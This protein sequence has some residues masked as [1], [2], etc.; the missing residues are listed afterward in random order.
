MFA[1]KPRVESLPLGYQ[2]IQEE[3]T[4]RNRQVEARWI[5]FTTPL[6]AYDTCTYLECSLSLPEL[7]MHL[8]FRCTLVTLVRLRTALYPSV[9]LK[10]LTMSKVIPC[11]VE[12]ILLG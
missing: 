12:R 3:L 10:E 8:R 5:A 9:H 11:Y 7:G 6:D 4:T 1:T 2:Y